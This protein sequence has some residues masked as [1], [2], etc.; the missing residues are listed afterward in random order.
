M[1]SKDEKSMQGFMM[2]VLI[3]AVVSLISETTAIVIAIL[4]V[5]LEVSLL[6]HKFD[7]EETK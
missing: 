4:L 5:A 2:W 7:K 3:L 1:T 6:S